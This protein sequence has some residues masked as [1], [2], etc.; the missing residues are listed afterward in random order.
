MTHGIIIST[1]SGIIVP[2]Y[3]SSV[4]QDLPNGEG[5]FRHV[6]ENGGVFE[7]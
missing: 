6:S 2:V 4:F 7:F 1:T 3:V 5:S